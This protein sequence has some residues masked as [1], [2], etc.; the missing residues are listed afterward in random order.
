MTDK[1]L[2][3]LEKLLANSIDRMQRNSSA[4]RRSKL[5]LLCLAGV[6]A[7]TLFM[8]PKSSGP[9]DNRIAANDCKHYEAVTADYKIPPLPDIVV[10]SSQAGSI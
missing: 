4:F 3:E 6:F 1:K 7:I 9:V 5:G 2:L 10:L 8:L